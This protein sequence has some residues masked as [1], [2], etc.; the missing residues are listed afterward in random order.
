MRAGL[1]QPGV[2][3]PALFDVP[4]MLPQPAVLGV[5]NVQQRKMQQSSFR[6]AVMWR[7]LWKRRVRRGS[8]RQFWRRR[9]CPKN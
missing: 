3:H 2:E 7:N 6:C 8:A 5:R 9:V 4:R 1:E